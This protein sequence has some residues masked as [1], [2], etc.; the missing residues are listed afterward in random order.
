MATN[1]QIYA[2]SDRTGE[3]ELIDDLYWFEE[4]GVHDFHRGEGLHDTFTFE[5]FIDNIRV[6]TN[7]Q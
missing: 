3:Q 5:I 1:V 7:E 4:N 2:T 6:W